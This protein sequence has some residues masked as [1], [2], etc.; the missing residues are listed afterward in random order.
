MKIMNLMMMMKYKKIGST[1]NQ[2]T[3]E[4]PPLDQQRRLGLDIDMIGAR[5]ENLG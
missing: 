4:I 1:N 2:K 3:E 5:E